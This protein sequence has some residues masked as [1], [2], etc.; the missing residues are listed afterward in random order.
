MLLSCCV[1]LP[2]GE[3]ARHLLILPAYPVYSLLPYVAMAIGFANM[4]TLRTLGRRLFTDHY[5]PRL[6]VDGRATKPAT[7][8]L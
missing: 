3:R 2:R 1:T 4:L 7:E 5:E 8:S 6:P